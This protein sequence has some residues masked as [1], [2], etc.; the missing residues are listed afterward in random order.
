LIFRSQSEELYGKPRPREKH[1]RSATRPANPFVKS[2]ILLEEK[3]SSSGH[4]FTRHSFASAVAAG[5]REFLERRIQMK[6]AGRLALCFA[7]AVS[8]CGAQDVV[9]VVHG[10]VTKVDHGTNTV[11]VKTADG[12]EHTIKVTGQ[13]T[14]KGSK[15]GFDGLKEGTEVVVHE[16]GKG[17]EETGLEIGKIGK[18]GVKVSEGTIVNVDHG[19]KTVVVKSA[20]GTEKTFEY[21]EKAG[22]D[23]GKAV[24]AGTAKG[25]KVTVYYTEETGK[26]IAHFFRF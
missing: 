22:K 16:T 15:E 23:M 8:I 20:D 26:K 21:T 13:T 10:T 5:W 9:S 11:V 6:K 18:E 12:T 4:G 19:T 25:A 14:Y 24:G 17:T 3:R 7:V 1:E 2:S